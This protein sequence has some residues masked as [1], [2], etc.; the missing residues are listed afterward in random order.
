VPVVAPARLRRELHVSALDAQRTQALRQFTQ[1]LFAI[2]CQLEIRARCCG[3]V[4][5]HASICRK[6]QDRGIGYSEIFDGIGARVIVDKVEEC[7]RL[8]ARVTARYAQRKSLAR[9]Y[10]AHPKHN[11]Y[12]SLHASVLSDD[13]FRIEVQIRTRSMHAVSERGTAAH[14]EYKPTWP[15]QPCPLLRHAPLQ[16]FTPSP[17][18]DN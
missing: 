3:R 4:K 9:D 10:I 1:Q 15:H 16:L 6:M 17:L 5:A 11:G 7:Y 2:C 8:L 12:Q 13:G 18:L 14:S